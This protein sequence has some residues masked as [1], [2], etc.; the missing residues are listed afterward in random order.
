MLAEYLKGFYAYLFLH[1][2]F[3]LL[4]GLYDFPKIIELLLYLNDKDLYKLNSKIKLRPH[5]YF[6]GG[7]LLVNH[8]LD[9]KLI[10]KI[11]DVFYLLLTKINK[12]HQKL[13]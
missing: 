4:N 2:N 11:L 9:Q 1:S 10:V 13:F 8:S 5:E 6:R 7:Y 12:F 3:M